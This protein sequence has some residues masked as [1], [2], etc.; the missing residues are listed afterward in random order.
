MGLLGFCHGWKPAPQSCN[1]C[2]GGATNFSKG[3][4]AATRG[5]PMLAATS[6]L[7]VVLTLLFAASAAQAAT[8]QELFEKYNLIGTFAIDCSQPVSKSN[9]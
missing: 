3:L 9:L 2:C 5:Q 4:P 6:R 7:P 1:H 8:V